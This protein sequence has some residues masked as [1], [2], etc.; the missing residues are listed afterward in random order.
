ML[1]RQRAESVPSVHI[2]GTLR[3]RAAAVLASLTL[4]AAAVWLLALPH[5]NFD[6]RVYRGSVD[7]WVFHG[8]LYSFGMGK[9]HYG[10][11]YPPFAALCMLP[12]LLLPLASVVVLNMAVIVSCAALIVRVVVARLPSLLGVDPWLLAGLLTPP[13]FL[14]QPLRDTLTFGQINIGLAALVTLDLLLLERGN[15]WAGVG[16]GLATALKLTPGLFVILYLVSGSRRAARTSALTFAAVT[17][18]SAAVAPST[19]WTFWTSTLYDSHRV[20]SYDSATNQSFAGV[21]AR[22]TNSAHVPAGWLPLV[23]AI[24]AYALWSA[25][26]LFLAGAL[27]PA[28][29]AVG[30][31][32]AVASPISWVHHLWWIAPALLI[33]LDQG[34]RQRSRGRLLVVAV[35]GLVFV[36]GMPDVMRA[37]AGHHLDS[38]ATI[39]GENAY[40]IAL[41]ILLALVCR[42][43]SSWPEPRG[44]RPLKSSGV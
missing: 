19:S 18:L 23:V 30:L 38:A 41:L 12:M 35:I 8:D 6:L 29:T 32:A 44:G 21:L 11:T 33:L 15:R 27:L 14:L 13:L 1:A 7:W 28:F 37:P 5:G 9:R 26:R 22:L 39:I 16:A 31:A 42:L 43:P 10:F 4:S 3:V 20:G 36:S 40:G 2:D 34:L 24:A 25:R 17:A